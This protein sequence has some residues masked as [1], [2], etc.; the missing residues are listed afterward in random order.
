MTPHLA[1]FETEYTVS[2]RSGL[3]RCNKILFPSP[4]IQAISAYLNSP[5]PIPYTAE[6]QLPYITVWSSN[7][8]PYLTA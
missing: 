8:P 4:G 5:Y 7:G 6:H 3:Q 1:P 2:F